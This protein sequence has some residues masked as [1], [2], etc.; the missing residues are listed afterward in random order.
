M[1]K[2]Y[3][4]SHLGPNFQKDKKKKSHFL[5]F[6]I[7]KHN[8]SLIRIPR[9]LNKTFMQIT[10]I[11]PP[12]ALAWGHSSSLHSPSPSQPKGPGLKP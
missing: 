7:S 2:L 1:L 10:L 4:P 8:R 5:I 12:T 11:K 6:S 9:T 3:M